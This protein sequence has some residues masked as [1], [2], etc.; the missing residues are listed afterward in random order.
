MSEFEEMTDEYLRNTYVPDVYQKNIYGVDY[1]RLQ[2][3]GIKV[4]SFDIDGTIATSTEHRPPK[5][6]ITLFENL[7]QMGF[8]VY[9]F[10]NTRFEHRAERYGTRMSVEFIF[11]AHKPNTGGLAEIQERYFQKYGVRLQKSQMAHIGNSI[12]SDVAVG[13]TFGILT[14]LVRNDGLIAK[15]FGNEGKRLRHELKKR[16]IWRKHHKEERHDQYYQ[17]NEV[18]AY[19]K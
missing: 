6:A 12:I 13:N 1:H 11:H 3:A 17:L 18:P 2:Q 8:E 16:G 19:L 15:T 7:K 9:L 10:S 14:V 4:L 5:E